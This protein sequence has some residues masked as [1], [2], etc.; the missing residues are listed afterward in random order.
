MLL[1]IKTWKVQQTLRNRLFKS[2]CKII[3]LGSLALVTARVHGISYAGYN[4]DL[5][6][7]VNWYAAGTPVLQIGDTLYLPQASPVGITGLGTNGL[8]IQESGNVTGNISV[9]DDSNANISTAIS[10]TV[11]MGENSTLSISGTINGAVTTGADSVIT[12]SGAASLPGGIVGNSSVLNFTTGTFTPPTSVTGINTL[13]VNSGTFTLSNAYP[14]TTALNIASGATLSLAASLSTSLAETTNNGSLNLNIASA[15]PAGELTNSST[16]TITLGASQSLNNITT[17]EGTIGLGI[18]TLTNNG[19]FTN[20]G[21]IQN[22][23]F[24]NYGTFN[25]TS[26][27]ITTTVFNN[28]NIMNLYGNFAPSNSFTSVNGSVY[29]AGG[30][31]SKSIANAS[32]LYLGQDSNG[33][34]YADT[35]TSGGTITGV[36]EIRVFT[37]STFTISDNTSVTTSFTVDNNATLTVSSGVVSGSGGST[38]T[39]SG[40]TTL[41]GGT[42]TVPV[43]VNNNIFNITGSTWNAASHTSITNTGTIYVVSPGNITFPATLSINGIL[44]IGKSYSGTIAD[45]TIASANTFTIPIINIYGDSTISGTLVTSNVYLASSGA[46]NQPIGATV[47]GNSLTIGMDSYGTMYSPTVTLGTVTRFPSIYVRGG[48]LTTSGSYSNVNIGLNVSSGATVNIANSFSG[49]AVSNTNSG[50][51]NLTSTLNLPNFTNASGGIFNLNGGATL[52]ST[53]TLNNYSTGL[54]TVAAPGLKVNG[55]N[56]NNGTINNY[57]TMTFLGTLNGIAGQVINQSGGILTFSTATIT[58]NIITNN[59]GGIF[60]IS[61]ASEFY[62]DID[63]Y[64]YM[65]ISADI[66]TPNSLTITNKDGG[67]LVLSSTNT[68][69]SLI[70][71]EEGGNLSIEGDTTLSGPNI[72]NNAGTLNITGSIT[73]GIEIDN[74]STGSMVIDGA[75]IATDVLNYGELEISGNDVTNNATIANTSNTTITTSVLGSGIISNSGVL[76]LDIGADKN[77]LNAIS[78]QLGGTI[79]II[80]QLQISN[81]FTNSGD[82]T[83]SSNLVMPDASYNFETTATGT[84]T[85][86]GNVSITTANATSYINAGTHITSIT[87]P[88]DFDSLTASG[89]IDLTGATLEIL[90]YVTNTSGQVQN[91]VILSGSSITGSPTITGISSDFYQIMELVNNGSS[92]VVS[93][94]AEQVTLPVNIEIANVLQNMFNNI[95]NSGQQTLE[96]AFLSIHRQLNN[97]LHQMMPIS[98]AFVYDAKMQDIIFNKVDVRLVGLRNGWNGSIHGGINAGEIYPGSAMWISTSGSLTEQGPDGENDGYNAKTGIAL[99]GLDI[100]ACNNVIGIAGGYSYTHL[101]ELSNV[102]FI[103]N[104]QRWHLMGYGS[105]AIDHNNYWDWLV[106]SNF[107]NNQ[108]HRDINVSGNDFT[109]YSTYHAYQVAGRITRGRGFDFLNSYRFTPYTFAQYAF[110]HQDAYNET[111]SV[112]ALNVESVNKNIVTLGL[113]ARFGF[114]LDAW[115][116]IGMREL[117]AAVTYDIVN[118]NNDTT[119]NF[120]VGS[121]SFTISNSPVRLGVQLGAG[122]AFEFAN[123]F[124]LELDYDFEVRSHFTDNT[125]LIKLKYVF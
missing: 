54:G 43:F 5:P 86:D 7:Y 37:G 117:R 80:S 45:T 4:I 59:S 77:I 123:H 115:H 63:N 9:G 66:S 94:N 105:Y 82:I 21:N 83:L 87:S 12:L 91:Y 74:L 39:N 72:L 8:A 24:N 18:Y 23:T 100:C 102:G 41:S 124:I 38:F 60:N 16:G 64:G 90:P 92:I 108:A 46:M 122:I 121:D 17:N 116:C 49:S 19:N 120:V 104:I 85:I 73:G 55:S 14:L 29:V 97:S 6:G 10:G 52:S 44:N 3:M 34:T 1:R 110:I 75:T 27:T 40:I 62:G 95:T 61:A 114:P 106:T 96:D 78:N 57:G 28:Y 13:N 103:D 125:A 2:S 22:S 93:I 107:N 51:V 89:I 70:E 65:T 11:T 84:V 47:G 30:N 88:S 69:T 25:Y 68:I 112:A 56:T 50:T 42:L 20:T 48:T 113:G 33:T 109:T 81:T 15:L 26:G 76:T 36:G 35:Y 118:N 99:F 53:T 31:L 32:K 71:N 67:E 111:G 98:N 119:A 58:E 79:D 101:K